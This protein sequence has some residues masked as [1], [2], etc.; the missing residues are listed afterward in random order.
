MPSITG[1]FYS[2]IMKVKPASKDSPAVIFSANRRSKILFSENSAAAE[3]KPE[4]IFSAVNHGKFLFSDN[5]GET[6]V[7]RLAR[8]DFQCQ[9]SK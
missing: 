5:E 2:V 4:V 7:E 9:P 3:V 1:K 8:S 6:G